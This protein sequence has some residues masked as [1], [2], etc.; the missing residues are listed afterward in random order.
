MACMFRRN[1]YAWIWECLLLGQV[2]VQKTGFV[3]VI[4]RE[5]PEAEGRP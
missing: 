1:L 3:V 2:F 5:M 4:P